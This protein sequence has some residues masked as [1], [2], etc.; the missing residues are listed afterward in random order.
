MI[1]AL[2]EILTEEEIKFLAEILLESWYA[3]DVRNMSNEKENCI[4]QFN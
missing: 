1:D 4:Y 3:L 2:G